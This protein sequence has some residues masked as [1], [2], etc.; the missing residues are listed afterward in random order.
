MEQLRSNGMMR[1]VSERHVV[2]NAL[3]A[4]AQT[5]LLNARNQAKS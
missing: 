1:V 2:D 3:D 5:A 4:V